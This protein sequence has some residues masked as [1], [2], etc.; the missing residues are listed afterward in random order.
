MTV[1][2]VICRRLGFQYVRRQQPSGVV[3]IGN[4]LSKIVTPLAAGTPDITDP[5]FAVT[6]VTLLPAPNDLT[7]ALV[8]IHLSMGR[9]HPAKMLVEALC[10]DPR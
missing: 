10:S 8:L 9:F 1:I 4:A 6:A 7:D 5:G 2:T 3:S